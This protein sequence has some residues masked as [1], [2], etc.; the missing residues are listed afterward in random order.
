VLVSFLTVMWYQKQKLIRGRTQFFL[1]LLKAGLCSVEYSRQ[2][3]MI[4]YVK[5]VMRFRVLA[6]FR[7]R[8]WS[9]GWS[10]ERR[11]L[12]YR[13]AVGACVNAAVVGLAR[14]GYRTGVSQGDFSRSLSILK[15]L[16]DRSIAIT[17]EVKYSWL[18]R[19]VLVVVGRQLLKQW[20][21]LGRQAVWIYF[22][23]LSIRLRLH[24]RSVGSQIIVV[25]ST[26]WCVLLLLSSS[27]IELRRTSCLRL[28]WDLS[29]EH[30]T[31][32]YFFVVVH[33]IFA[34]LCDCRMTN[35]I[36][37]FRLMALHWR[38]MLK[39]S[40]F[41]EFYS[42]SKLRLLS[43]IKVDNFENWYC[44]TKSTCRQ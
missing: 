39:I 7:R 25:D 32:R 21:I 22:D 36:L 2:A 10:A 12:P 42:V 4:C 17:M 15:F 1:A 35:I 27:G 8:R 38:L 5:F 20:L 44:G 34:V 24:G 13:Q 6:V 14:H 3:T 18:Q 19:R 43:K 30:F 29:W 41:L 16:F 23:C 9:R 37:L 26:P 40:C 33:V 11:C 28:Y 31:C